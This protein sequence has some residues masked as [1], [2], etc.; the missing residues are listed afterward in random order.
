MWLTHTFFAYY[1]FQDFVLL[2]RVS[3]LIYLWLIII[4]LITAIILEKIYTLLN[5]VFEN[6]IKEVGK[7]IHKYLRSKSSFSG[8]LS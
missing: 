1:Y 5:L 4:S 7:P 6:I 8:N 2:P 3:I